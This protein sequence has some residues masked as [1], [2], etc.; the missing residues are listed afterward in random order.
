[1]IYTVKGVLLG[2]PYTV[3]WDDGKIRGTEIIK[4]IIQAEAKAYEGVPIGPVGQYTEKAHLKNPLSA[5]FL[6]RNIFDEI[7]AV[8]GDVPE[9]DELPEG[10]V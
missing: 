7:L 9:A 8:T 4:D 3:Q 10:A 1:M 5:L 2:T 6:M